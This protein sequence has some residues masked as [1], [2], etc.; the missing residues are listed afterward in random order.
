MMKAKSVIGSRT[1]MESYR[2]IVYRHWMDGWAGRRIGI[3]RACI[4][5]CKMHA[6][7]RGWM[8]GCVCVCVCVRVRL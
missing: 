7:V 3:H 6:C 8:G 2:Y 4:S 5:I 1:H